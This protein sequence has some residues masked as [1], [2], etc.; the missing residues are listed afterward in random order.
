MLHWL[1][2]MNAVFIFYTKSIKLH[3]SLQETRLENLLGNYRPEKKKKKKS[4]P[5]FH[6][7]KVLFRMIVVYHHFEMVAPSS[8]RGNHAILILLT[9]EMFPVYLF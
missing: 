9:W 6:I 8:D 1:K 2:D 5:D 3:I 7:W 4:S